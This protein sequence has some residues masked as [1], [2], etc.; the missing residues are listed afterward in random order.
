M[1]DPRRKRHNDDRARALLEFQEPLNDALWKSD[2]RAWKLIQE[3]HEASKRDQP[4]WLPEWAEFIAKPAAFAA[5]DRF[6]E[7]SADA[8]RRAIAGRPVVLSTIDHTFTARTPLPW[9][10]DNL[11][12]VVAPLTWHVCLELLVALLDR[13]ILLN[14]F[15]PG[16]PLRI[17]RAY[18]ASRRSELIRVEHSLWQLAS[19]HGATNDTIPYAYRLVLLLMAWD[20][21]AHNAA[22]GG[23]TLCIRCGGLL[24]RRRRFNS[25]P[26]CAV[27]MKETAK[28]RKW[29]SH[30]IGP[31]RRATWLLRCQYP[32]CH[33]IYESPRHQQLCPNHT[34]SG[35]PPKRRRANVTRGR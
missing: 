3:V 30:T 1:I 19:E 4:A 12:N 5:A 27:C 8:L 9:V 35:L 7:S 15:S 24:H 16:A 26:R 2:P 23:W 22:D 11:L 33:A 21:A 14:D 32:D 28:Q 20:P 29:P 18:H 25:M 13:S 17:E 31:H 34:S 10:G 6:R